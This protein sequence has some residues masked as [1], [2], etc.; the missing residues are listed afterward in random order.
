[1]SVLGDIVLKDLDI[2]GEKITFSGG[3][4]ALSDYIRFD[5]PCLQTSWQ[6][7]DATVY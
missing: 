3:Y 5:Q 2:T 1:V 4:L 7:V 6:Y